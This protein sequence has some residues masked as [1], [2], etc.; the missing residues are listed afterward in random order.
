MA[1]LEIGL[2]SPRWRTVV[3]IAIVRIARAVHPVAPRIA[4]RLAQAACA[5]V[6]RGL[7]V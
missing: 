7:R 6:S 5:F 1:A 4:L 3:A 2:R